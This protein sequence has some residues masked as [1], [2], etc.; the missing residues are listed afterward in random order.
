M[1]L[2]LFILP[3]I[4]PTNYLINCVLVQERVHVFLFSQGADRPNLEAV[5]ARASVHVCFERARVSVSVCVLLAPYCWRP[6]AYRMWNFRSNS[7]FKHQKTHPYE[8]SALTLL[9]VNTDTENSRCICRTLV[10]ENL[11]LHALWFTDLL[12]HVI[13]SA[14]P[15]D[16]HNLQ[17]RRLKN[18]DNVVKQRRQMW[19]NI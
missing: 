2:L 15:A 8:A 10:R 9:R 19:N 6:P 3:L 4:S 17:W 16:A 1:C 11:R 13:R 12:I 7:S 5:H 18:W 14:I